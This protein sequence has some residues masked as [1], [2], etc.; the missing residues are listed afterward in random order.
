MPARCQPVDVRRLADRVAVTGERGVGQVIGDDEQHIVF[1]LHGNGRFVFHVG[2]CRS[3]R[4]DAFFG[5]L[6]SDVRPLPPDAQ[7]L[8]DRKPAVA[9]RIQCGKHLLGQVWIRTQLRRVLDE[10]HTLNQ[11]ISVLV[12]PLND[13]F[14]F[15]RNDSVQDILGPRNHSVRVAI[16]RS[17]N[18]RPCLGRHIDAFLHVFLP[19]V[20]AVSIRV[21]SVE[22]PGVIVE[23]VCRRSLLKSCSQS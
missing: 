8:G 1:R 2:E 21:R 6:V 7:V 3:V 12:H 18:A 5:R 15:I 19:R 20:L 4:R 16:G 9:V 10:L 23:R 13:R 11:T 22:V 17:E 14:G